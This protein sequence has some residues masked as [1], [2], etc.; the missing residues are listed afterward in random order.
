MSLRAR[1]IGAFVAL[2]LAVIALVGIVAFRSTRAVLM[3]QI[4]EQLATASSSDIFPA[5]G[6]ESEP[7]GRRLAVVI[8]DENGRVTRSL[9]SG[10]PGRFD[11]LP[12]T[13]QAEEATIRGGRFFTLPAIEGDVEYRALAVRA[14]DGRTFVIAH[15]LAEVGAA[16]AAIARRLLFGGGLVLLAGIGGVW[17]TVSRGMKPVDD[18]VDT[19]SAIA[20]GELSRRVPEAG[21]G[22]ELGK[23]GASLNEMLASIEHA[24][25]AETQARARIK[26]FVADASHELRTPLAVIRGYTELDRRGALDD[27]KARERVA[28]R[29]ESETQRMSRLVDDLMLLARFDLDDDD[30]SPLRIR[31]VDLAA[32]AREVVADHMTIDPGHPVG[33]AG[34]ETALIAGDPERLTQVLGNLLANL[35]AHTPPGTGAGMLIEDQGDVVVVRLTDQGP[36]F[37]PGTSAQ[38]F[39]RFFRADPG[40][41]RSGGTGLGLSIAA[42]IVEAHRGSITAENHD[43]GG[44][45]LT[46]RLP[47]GDRRDLGEAEASR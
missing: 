5:L 10:F 11:P 13:S 39:E 45:V 41:V 42:A 17:I 2:V 30:A 21:P 20:A 25:D 9:P 4:E 7:V 29:I 27:P 36:G 33:L 14:R 40:R 34:V 24:F 3:L 19:A 46:V 23:L 1:L 8:L 6:R 28:R 12:D 26:Q 47:R 44:A 16:Q 15:N 38:A 43:G 22:T 35:R 32:I 18:M 37:P 31:R